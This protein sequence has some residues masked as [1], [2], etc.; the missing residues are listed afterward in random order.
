[1]LSRDTAYAAYIVFKIPVGSYGLDYPPQKAS[2]D[3]VAGK[4]II[5]KVCLQSYEGRHV[6]R[7]VTVPLTPEY[8]KRVSK[9]KKEYNK[10]YRRGHGRNPVLPQERTDGWME[11][12]MGVFYNKEGADGEVRFSLLQT[13]GTSKEGLIVQGIEIRPKKLG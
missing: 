6:N 4:K 12:E 2:I 3:T 11:L 13:S 10:S 1:M 9:K 5:R 8:N 7:Q